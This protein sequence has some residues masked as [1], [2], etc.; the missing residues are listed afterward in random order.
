MR[1][2]PAPIKSILGLKRY[3]CPFILRKK[4]FSI[5]SLDCYNWHR[6]Q[7]IMNKRAESSMKFNDSFLCPFCSACFSLNLSPI[8]GNPLG[9]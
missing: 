7:R 3:R 6:D 9:R 1:E 5:F 2:F 8:I 4:L